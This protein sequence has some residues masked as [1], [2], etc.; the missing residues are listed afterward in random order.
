MQLQFGHH[1]RLGEGTVSARL[2]ADLPVVD[3][4]VALVLF[5]V[6]DQRRT[7][8]HGLA[9]VDD[10][11]Q[12]FVLDDDRLTRVLGDIRVVGDHACHFLALEAHLVRGE[13]RLGVV[14]QRRHPGQVAR[15]HHLSGEHQPHT[16]NLPGLAG[17]D[18]LDPGMGQGASKDLHVQ[19]SRQHDVVDIGAPATDEPVVLDAL[20]PRAQPADFDLVECGHDDGSRLDQLADCDCS[21]FAAHSTDLTMFW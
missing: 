6:T 18:G 15:G 9:G 8:G 3:D 1:I 2:V 12:R 11:R 13:H 14:G 5:V 10:R 17:I 21:F 19:H 20:A 4:V 16:G 7:L